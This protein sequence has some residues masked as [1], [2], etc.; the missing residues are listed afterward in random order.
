MIV[1]YHGKQFIK[2]QHGDTILA[3]N[4]ISKDSKSEK[5][6]TKFGSDI[7]MISINHPDY[8]GVENA[9]YAGKDPFVIKGPGEY[10]IGDLYI[11][12]FLSN[13]KIDKEDYINTIYS[14]GIDNIQTWFLGSLDSPDV[15]K[16]VLE[17]VEEVDLLFISINEDSGVGPV[18]AAKVIKMFSPKL[19]VPIDYGE[20]SDKNLKAFLKEMGQENIKAE[21]KLTI[22]RKDLDGKAGEVF[23]LKK[24]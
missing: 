9:S 13:I 11:Q 17:Y 16:S 22:K 19:V 2:V 18:E 20:V 6:P 3:L 15:D 8:N 14:F 5:K 4:P 1:T 7:C 23:V 10:E 24:S 21:D 12:G